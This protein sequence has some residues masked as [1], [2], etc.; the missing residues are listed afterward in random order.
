M[1]CE[2]NQ[3]ECMGLYI[4]LKEKGVVSEDWKKLLDELFDIFDEAYD[5]DEPVN[6]LLEEIA[7]CLV[8]IVDETKTD[9]E[10]EWY[11][12]YVAEGVR[13]YR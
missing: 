1:S 9:V 8:D 12:G 2:D 4:T 10:L 6:G 5:N 13:R 7:S 11:I 3:A